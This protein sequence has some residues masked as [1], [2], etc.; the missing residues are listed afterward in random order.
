MPGGAALAARQGGRIGKDNVMLPVYDYRKT[1]AVM[2]V[3]ELIERLHDSPPEAG[4]F[5]GPYEPEPVEGLAP[6]RE[7]VT[8]VYTTTWHGT[9]DEPGN[10]IAYALIACE[11][12][13]K[14]AS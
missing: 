3:G 13:G 7:P 5:I 1:G 12:I 14:A 9:P 6:P 4:V 10:V 8:H 2:T 11:D